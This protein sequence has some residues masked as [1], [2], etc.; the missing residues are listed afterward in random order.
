MGE[1]SLPTKAEREAQKKKRAGPQWESDVP[2][3]VVVEDA[4]KLDKEDTY[5]FTQLRVLSGCARGE[6]YEIKWNR[7]WPSGDWKDDTLALLETVLVEGDPEDKPVWSYELVDKCFKLT[8]VKST[9]KND[10]IYWNFKDIFPSEIPEEDRGTMGD[11]Y[12]AANKVAAS[13]A[14]FGGPATDEIPF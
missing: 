11:Q 1:Q 4:G 6:L 10:R 14:S 8:P 7:Q 5:F 9:G 12:P 2:I 13:P 3:I